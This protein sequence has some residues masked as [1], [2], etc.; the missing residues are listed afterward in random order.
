MKR[1]LARALIAILL[2]LGS[3]AHVSGIYNLS[4]IHI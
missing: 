4:L 2:T 1:Y 3:L